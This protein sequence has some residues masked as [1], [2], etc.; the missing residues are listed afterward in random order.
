MFV[1]SSIFFVEAEFLINLWDSLPIFLIVSGKTYMWIFI[2][3]VSL[4]LSLCVFVSVRVCVFVCIHVCKLLRFD[5]IQ[6]YCYTQKNQPML[7]F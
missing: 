6:F 1:S 5:K 7:W 4:S 3:V 2:T